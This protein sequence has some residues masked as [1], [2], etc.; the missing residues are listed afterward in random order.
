[1][2]TSKGVACPPTA[3]DLTAETIIPSDG[4]SGHPMMD[5]RAAD[6]SGSSPLITVPEEPPDWSSSSLPLPHQPIH[7]WLKLEAAL[8]CQRPSVDGIGADE[9]HWFECCAVSWQLNAQN[10]N[11]ASVCPDA[12]GHSS[13]RWSDAVYQHVC[14]AGLFFAVS[15]KKLAAATASEKR[16]KHTRYIMWCFLIWHMSL[17]AYIRHRMCHTYKRQVKLSQA[18][19]QVDA[20]S[21]ASIGAGIGKWDSGVSRCCAACFSMRSICV[22]H[23]RISVVPF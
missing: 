8:E 5:N 2:K 20:F 1:M 15:R 16:T 13:P 14:K 10:V 18:M 7:H 21:G 19:T 12:L 6:V 22:C 23:T 11:C 4:F 9:M 17:D 3:R